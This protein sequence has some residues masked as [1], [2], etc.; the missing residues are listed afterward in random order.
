MLVQKCNVSQDYNATCIDVVPTVGV[1]ST[2]KR[3]NPLYFGFTSRV[4]WIDVHFVM[5][6]TRDHTQ[7]NARRNLYFTV[8]IPSNLKFKFLSFLTARPT[9]INANLRGA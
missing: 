6:S 8:S 5:Y 9:L 2:F 4:G 7:N 3:I 1:T